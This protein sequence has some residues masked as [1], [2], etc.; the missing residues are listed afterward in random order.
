MSEEN[1]KLFVGN[2]PFSLDSDGLK[3]LFAGVGEVV[4]AA[5]ISDKFSGR[6]K[7]FGFVTMADGETA[8]KAVKELN[9]KDVDGRQLKVDVARPKRDNFER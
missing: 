8:Q 4:E 2:L 6:S 1:N 5:V 9:G 3:A 7:G